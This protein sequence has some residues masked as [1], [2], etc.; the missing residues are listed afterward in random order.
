MNYYICP[1][2][3]TK[4]PVS[5][6]WFKCLQPNDRSR[7]AHEKY[8][9]DVEDAISGTARRFP[10]NFLE[11][12][13]KLPKIDT[14]CYE[15][16]DGNDIRNQYYS[17]IVDNHIFK[18]SRQT[19]GRQYSE[20]SIPA[21]AECPYCEGKHRVFTHVCPNPACNKEL[22]INE[23]EHQYIINLAG[24]MSNGKS[25]FL[26]A[27]LYSIDR[28]LPHLTSWNVN[29]D[30]NARKYKA[31]FINYMVNGK[32]MERTDNSTDLSNKVASVSLNRGDQEKYTFIFYDVHGELFNVTDD[33][34]L[35]KSAKQFLDPNFIIMVCDPSNF[36]EVRKAVLDDPNISDTI[37]KSFQS[38]CPIVGQTGN[39]VIGT[40]LNDNN[41]NPYDP[42]GMDRTP[43]NSTQEVEIPL[44]S[45]VV[46]QIISFMRVLDTINADY[47]GVSRGKRSIPFALCV[48]KSDLINEVF[49][50][51][52]E[53]AKILEPSSLTSSN[54]RELSYNKFAV[55]SKK[56][57]NEFKS[58][59][60]ETWFERA[61]VGEID[62]NFPNSYYCAIS[63]RGYNADKITRADHITPTGV[64]DPF[65]WI[66]N[67][68]NL[69]FFNARGS[70]DATETG[71]YSPVDNEETF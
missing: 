19:V 14:I 34:Q 5:E 55:N 33:A 63:A 70:S 28:Y 35:F 48:T 25:V 49:S 26:G 46:T 6:V 18:A 58:V 54:L 62:S 53:I 9:K 39:T 2:C 60:D 61:L 20:N 36:E 24:G 31:A 59:L 71:S 42:M 11:Y 30:D 52:K 1:H 16:D 8:R 12:Y 29:L 38:N 57:S 27:L 7:R 37:K 22:R 65:V 13:A 51:D 4:F 41:L 67:S 17:S 68:V 44:P 40:D 23:N 66:L 45:Q 15:D 10:R 3:L 56:R 43:D 32:K 47:T 21:V 50:E 64:L 69:Q